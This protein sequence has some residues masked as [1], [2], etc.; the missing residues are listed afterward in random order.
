M[1]V[2]SGYMP[3]EYAMHK[4]FSI[5]SDVYSFGILLLEIL[6][7]NKNSS[8]STSNDA[9]NMLSYVSTNQI[10]QFFVYFVNLSLP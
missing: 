5:K 1:L 2:S 6:S 3:P 7:G 9:D 8:F 10:L 4:Q